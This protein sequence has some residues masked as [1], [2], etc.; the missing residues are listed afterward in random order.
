MVDGKSIVT[1]AMRQE[2]ERLR[3]EAEKE[4]EQRNRELQKELK[5]EVKGG[6]AKID[7]K[8]KQLAH[9]LEQSQVCEKC[10]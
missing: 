5:K 2:E 8:F 7:V 4:E 1:E 9:L 6:K 3:L 10:C